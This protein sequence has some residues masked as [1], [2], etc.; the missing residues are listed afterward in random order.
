MVSMFTNKPNVNI[1]LVVPSVAEEGLIQISEKNDNLR[2]VSIGVGCDLKNSF[3]RK[4]RYNYCSYVNN[5]MVEV[6]SS[7]RPIDIVHVLFGLYLTEKLNTAFLKQNGIV[8][9][10]TIHN[11]PP[12]ECGVSWDSDLIFSRR[13]IV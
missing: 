11:L 1:I 12:A 7:G 4:N 3:P 8:A 13:K 9:I 6:V 2:I 5:Y 10:N